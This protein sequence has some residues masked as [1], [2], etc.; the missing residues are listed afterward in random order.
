MSPAG[1][2]WPQADFP[3]KVHCCCTDILVCCLHWSHVWQLR[4]VLLVMY[5]GRSVFRQA[6]QHLCSLIFVNSTLFCSTAIVANSM[7]IKCC[8]MLQA[9]DVTNNRNL[10]HYIT[11]MQCI[12]L[13]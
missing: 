1:C 7:V 13:T 6:V 11:G 12:E 9:S 5:C 4:L 8:V 2:W 10:Y 3:C